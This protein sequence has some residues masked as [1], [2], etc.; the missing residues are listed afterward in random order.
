MANLEISTAGLSE[1]ENDLQL[2]SKR[3]TEDHYLQRMGESFTH[4]TEVWE[5]AEQNHRFVWGGEDAQWQDVDGE[6]PATQR[7]AQGRAVL[8]ENQIARVINIVTGREITSRVRPEYSGTDDTDEDWLAI[9]RR[10]LKHTRQTADHEQAESDFFRNCTI[11]NISWIGWRQDR[12]RGPVSTGM[13]VVEPILHWE[14]RWDPAAREKNLLDRMWDARGYW[15]SFEDFAATFPDEAER[16]DELLSAGNEFWVD[17]AN[18]NKSGSWP[19]DYVTSS[20]RYLDMQRR[21]V[22]LVSYN[23]KELTHHYYTM[24]SAPGEPRAYHVFET[25]DELKEAAGA[26]PFPLQYVEVPR[27]KYREA[28]FVGREMIA[29]Y[30]LPYREFP[31]Q[32]MTSIPFRQPN[33]TRFYGPVDLTKDQQRMKNIVSS[34][35]VTAVQMSSKGNIIAEE[36]ALKDPVLAAEQYPKSG[37]IILAKQNQLDKI[38]EWPATQVPPHLVQLYEYVDRAFYAGL[39]INPGALGDLG[40]DLR[41]ISGNVVQSVKEAATMSLACIFDSLR[42][43][44]K[45]AGRLTL[46]FMRAHLD[47]DDLARIVGRKLSVHEVVDP[48]T[49]EVVQEIPLI[50]PKEEWE[51]MSTF[52]IVV[53]EADASVEDKLK[54]FEL[55]IQTG[56]IQ[57]E[58]NA[59]RA[60]ASIV[61]E[62]AGEFMQR[63]AAQ[64]WIEHA[65]R[66]D[67]AMM[68]GGGEEPPPEDQ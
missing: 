44:R 37:Q 20:G 61:P 68:A 11:E 26:S 43:Y 12:M 5:T 3:K 65:M 17:S 23:W 60:P 50:P 38:K 35:I 39:G 54:S 16:A 36:N 1:S 18:L 14:M 7:R 34:M 48:Q 52:D 2:T 22:F 51:S 29:E 58:V 67:K 53:D 46:D 9:C 49:G 24:V 30:D 57:N 55:L 10:Y 33:R 15:V 27:W 28:F 25:E 56:L 47:P 63:E 64:K 42:L 13:T 21:Q 45:I 66:Y 62:V 31:R 6:N 41:R 8:I 40:T 19:F 59:G 32:A 4:V